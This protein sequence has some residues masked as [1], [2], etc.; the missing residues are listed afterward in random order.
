MTMDEK[1]N[2]KMPNSKEK[3]D[4]GGEMN[5]ANCVCKEG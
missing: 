4:F 1:Q 3:I 5:M 2:K